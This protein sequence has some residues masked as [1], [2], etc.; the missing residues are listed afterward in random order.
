MYFCDSEGQLQEAQD[1]IEA[2]PG[3]AVARRGQV[4]V[5]F[6]NN[7]NTE[8]AIDLQTK[9]GKRLRTRLV[10]PR[11]ALRFISRTRCY[12]GRGRMALS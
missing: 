1:L 9:D 3:G 8:G 4:K 5:I 6:A 2:V 7:L 11:M 10:L 12:G